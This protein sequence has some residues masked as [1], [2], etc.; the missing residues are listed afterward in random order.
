MKHNIIKNLIDGARSVMIIFHRNY[1][2]Y[3]DKKGFS[4][5]ISRISGDF[6]TLGRDMRR[7]INKY[8]GVRY[9]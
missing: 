8:N 3:P 4:R 6:K 7:S 9:E 1:Y 5:D 2:L